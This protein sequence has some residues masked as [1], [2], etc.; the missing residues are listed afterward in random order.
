MKLLNRINNVLLQMTYSLLVKSRKAAS[1]IVTIVCVLFL[2]GC[3][4]DNSNN[5]VVPERARLIKI[6]P[7]ASV[8]ERF[9]PKMEFVFNKP[10][11]EVQ[12]NG[13]DAQ[14]NGSMPATIW[15]MDL[16]HFEQIHP[17]VYYENIPPERVCLTV[18]YTDGGSRHHEGLDCAVLGPIIVYS[19]VP[20][21]IAATVKDGDVE[22]DA[23][24]LNANGIL[25]EFNTLV[26]GKVAI[27]PGRVEDWNPEASLNW[28]VEW[29][30]TWVRLR[31]PPNGKKLLNGTV[32]TIRFNVDNGHGDS[33]IGK[34]TF[35]TKA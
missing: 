9:E 32:Y 4:N 14:P 1:Q 13:V 22:V 33:M 15:N 3:D 20:K 8:I 12:V 11:T 7:A 25:L 21:M 16:R 6:T 24:F 34:I 18:S 27:V 29:L 31:C 23:G 30:G 19:P 17:I 5:S 35:T 28:K 26:K 10:V 2:I